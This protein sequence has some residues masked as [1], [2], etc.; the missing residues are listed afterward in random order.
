M[1]RQTSDSA[2][3]VSLILK[4][5]AQKH[6]VQQMSHQRLNVGL[7]RNDRKSPGGAMLRALLVLQV[8]RYTGD[9]QKEA[10]MACPQ[11]ISCMYV[12]D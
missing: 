11:D 5:I 10:Q 9:I 6:R 8:V 12:Q 3:V 7:G 4:L 1:R 2:L